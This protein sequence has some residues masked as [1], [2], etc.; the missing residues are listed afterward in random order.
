M[1]TVGF[2]ACEFVPDR[3]AIQVWRQQIILLIL[4]FELQLETQIVHNIPSTDVTMGIYS[5][6][7]K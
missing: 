6:I 5:K 4:Q 2:H 1:A 7:S 3:F